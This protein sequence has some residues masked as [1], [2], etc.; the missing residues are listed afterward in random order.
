MT[1]R[2]LLSL[3]ALFLLNAVMSM[4]NLWPTPFVKLDKRLAP[5]FVL[6]WVTILLIVWRS[7]KLSAKWLVGLTVTYML[8]VTGRYFDTTAPALFGRDINLY[9]DGLQIPRVLWVSLK[10]YPLWISVLV[11]AFLV[12]LFWV[13]FL[14]LRW[15]IRTT[16]AHAAPYALRKPW[17]LLIT[18]AASVLVIAN[19]NGVRETW[20]YVSKPVLP[21]Y[22]RQAKLLFTAWNERD[23]QKVLPASP[24]FKSDLGAL[25]GRDVNL[26]FWESYGQV[27]YTV[28][29]INDGLLVAREALARQITASGMQVVS[30]YVSS[31][32]FGGASEL[33][34]IALLTGIDTGNPTVHDLLITTDRPTLTGLFQ[35]RGYDVHALYTALTWDWPEKVFYRFNRF[36]D[37]R[38]LGY[39]GP[40]LGYWTVPDQYALAR[41]QEMHPITA[42]SPKRL[43][44][45]PSITSHMPFHPVPPYQE[46]WKKL[47]SDTPFDSQQMAKVQAQK[48]DWFNMRP[49]YI[50]MMN[51]NYQWFKG[52]LAQPKARDALYIVMGDHQPAANVTGEGATWDVP[53]HIISSQPELLQRFIDRGFQKGLTPREPRIGAIFDFT[54]TILDALDSGANPVASSSA[55][56]SPSA[57][58]PALA[59]K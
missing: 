2:I 55:R 43:M 20:P 46:D 9:W 18:A 40:K 1:S 59:L 57:A 44:F 49:G 8:F 17:V 21:T 35:E 15:A 12:G 6:L 22:T 53:V 19:V 14:M 42:S 23:L 16:A 33:A 38:D 48:E 45:F 36:S 56:V 39:K 25:S 31:T 3:F 13:G 11:V 41:Y 47:L 50:G 10:S 4:T 7:H 28:P 52:W 34:H 5:E 58:Q 30:G 37:A 27:A 26:F 54:R 51:Y 32:T 24:P 29:Q